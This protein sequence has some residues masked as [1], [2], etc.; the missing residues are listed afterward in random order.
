MKRLALIAGGVAAASAALCCCPSCT[1][2]VYTILAASF[3]VDFFVNFDSD[4]SV[5]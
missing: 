4:D 1:V 3:L 5:C 2:P